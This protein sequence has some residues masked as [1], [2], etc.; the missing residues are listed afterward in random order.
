[1]VTLHPTHED[2]MVL[3]P[4]QLLNNIIKILLSILVLGMEIGDDLVE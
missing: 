1:M 4:M 3:L 2:P